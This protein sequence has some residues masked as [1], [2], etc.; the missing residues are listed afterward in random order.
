MSRVMGGEGRLP[1]VSQILVTTRKLN[2]TAARPA[3]NEG[4][5]IRQH[6]W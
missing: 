1:Y 5:L 3:A 6:F 2:K 4:V